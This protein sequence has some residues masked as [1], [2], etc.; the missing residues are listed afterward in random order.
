MFQVDAVERV[1]LSDVDALKRCLSHADATF[2]ITDPTLPD[3]PI[4]FASNSFLKLSGYTS[5]QVVGR[6]C[7]ILQGPDTNPEA[8]R[9]IAAAIHGRVGIEETLINYDAQGGRFWNHV[10]I[11]PL[12]DPDGQLTHFIGVQRVLREA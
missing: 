8:K 9:R 2:C 12:F 5:E 6:N 3:N 1:N 11:T 10:F 4:V 7:R